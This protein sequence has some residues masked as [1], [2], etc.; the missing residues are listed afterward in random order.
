MKKRKLRA[1][2]KKLQ[3]QVAEARSSAVAGAIAKMLI[4]NAIGEFGGQIVTVPKN[5]QEGEPEVIGALRRAA[6][7]AAARAKP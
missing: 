5:P 4:T 2:I 6:E 1:K 3:S 7:A